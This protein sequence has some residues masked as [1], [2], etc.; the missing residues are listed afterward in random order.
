[1]ALPLCKSSK[2]TKVFMSVVGPK[3]VLAPDCRPN[4]LNSRLQKVIFQYEK[5]FTFIKYSHSSPPSPKE[6]CFLN[7]PLQIILGLLMK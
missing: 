5:V 1:M 3:I 6:K 4:W 2:M 7:T